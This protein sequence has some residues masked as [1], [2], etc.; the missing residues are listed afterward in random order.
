MRFSTFFLG[1]A[2]LLATSAPSMAVA[3]DRNL[4][5]R[6]S[7]QRFTWY[8]VGGLVFLFDI[9][10]VRFGADVDLAIASAAGACGQYHSD[11]EFVSDRNSWL[12]T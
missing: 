6:F 7:G 3:I 2:Y 12:W 1:A 11:S 5:E 10:D 9:G 8:E 4:T